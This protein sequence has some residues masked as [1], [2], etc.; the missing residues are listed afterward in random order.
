MYSSSQ[1]ISFD[2]FTCRE[3]VASEEAY[4]ILFNKVSSVE[5]RSTIAINL[6][7]NIRFGW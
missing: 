1:K 2:K 7:G 3:A 6:L 4:L 5:I